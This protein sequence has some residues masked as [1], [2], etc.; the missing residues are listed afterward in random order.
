MSFNTLPSTA[1]KQISTND[2]ESLQS[3]NAI[4]EFAL[5]AAILKRESDARKQALD[6]CMTG[7]EIKENHSSASIVNVHGESLNDKPKKKQ[8]ILITDDKGAYGTQRQKGK[9]AIE[10]NDSVWNF[11]KMESK[12]NHSILEKSKW[13]LKKTEQVLNEEMHIVFKIG[14]NAFHQCDSLERELKYVKDLSNAR[15]LEIKRLQKSDKESRATI[16]VSLEK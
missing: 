5:A 9:R 14:V 3:P 13:A 6:S 10:D 4:A 8:R 12:T 11:A 16:S 1:P 2:D 7:E 15:Q